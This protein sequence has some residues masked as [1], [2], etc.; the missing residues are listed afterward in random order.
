M[1]HEANS[2]SAGLAFIQ[3]AAAAMPRTLGDRERI[4]AMDEAMQIAVR[5]RFAF[6]KDEAEA[7]N[8]YRISTCVGKFRPLDFYGM[9]CYHGG[10]YARMWETHH[11]QKPWVAAVAVFAGHWT[12]FAPREEVRPKNRVATSVAVLLPA[13]FSPYEALLAR[14]DDGHQVWWCTSMDADTITL[15]RYE[16]PNCGEGREDL[17]RY[18]YYHSGQKP[19]RIRKLSREEWEQW[20]TLMLEQAQEPQAA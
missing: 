5:N 14:T 3:A 12:S 19:A 17:M 4:A 15:C 20:N 1:K 11:K 7:L 10:T 16:W 13:S 8:R 18:P 2:V 6:D 9:A